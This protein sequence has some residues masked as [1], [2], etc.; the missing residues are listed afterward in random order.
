M[1]PR[2]LGYYL[3]FRRRVRHVKQPVRERFGLAEAGLPPVLELFI[4]LLT[5]CSTGCD[6]VDEDS[7]QS[8]YLR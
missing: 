8:F 7:G 1:V 6:G 5:C 4:G 2:I 3:H